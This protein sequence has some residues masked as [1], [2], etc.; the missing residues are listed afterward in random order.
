[1]ADRTRRPLHRLEGRPLASARHEHCRRES[2]PRRGRHQEGSHWMRKALQLALAMAALWP[3]ATAIGTTHNALMLNLANTV[4]NDGFLD[5]GRADPTL[6]RLEGNGQ[7]WFELMVVQGDDLGG[8]Q[9]SNTLDLRGW[10][11]DWVY[12]KALDDDAPNPIILGRARSRFR[13]I[14]CGRRC[15]RAR[16]SP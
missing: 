8:G 15:L 12:D 2:L 6:G 11:L 9:F 5:K 16:S 7:N 1:M 14:P 3:A 13:R 10:K 4:S